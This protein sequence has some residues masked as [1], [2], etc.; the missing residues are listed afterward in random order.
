MIEDL[1]KL[2]SEPV[3]SVLKVAKC[4]GLNKNGPL[5]AHIFAWPPGSGTD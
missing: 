4:D 1:E 5:K 2:P 3:E